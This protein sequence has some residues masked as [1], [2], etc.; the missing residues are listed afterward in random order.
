MKVMENRNVLKVT[1]SVLIYTFYRT[2]NYYNIFHGKKYKTM[3]QFLLLFLT[4]VCAVVCTQAQTD[5][6]SDSIIYNNCDVMPEFPGGN[7]A[8]MRYIGDHLQYP[9]TALKSGKQGKCVLRF[10]ITKDG[11]VGE[12][13]VLRSVSPECDAEAARVARTLKFS[14]GKQDGVLV[15]VWYTLPISFK[16][17]SSVPVSS[18]PCFVDSAGNVEIMPEFPGGDAALMKFLADNMVYPEISAKIKVSG[19]CVVRFLVTKTGDVDSIQIEQSLF[20][21]FDEAVI[22]V[23]KRLPKFKPGTRNGEPVDVW[24]TLPV[25]FRAPQPDPMEEYNRPDPT[26]P[27]NIDPGFVR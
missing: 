22:S 26:D 23:V 25:T 5:A 8:M 3:K 2:V 19:R 18:L 7:A 6:T 12:V 15:N 27:R 13:K 11:N 20:R 24:Y 1:K 4:C 9:E 17:A 10:V 14:P 21:P 16:L